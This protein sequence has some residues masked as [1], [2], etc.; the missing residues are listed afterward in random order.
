MNYYNIR[1]LSVSYFQKI[2]FYSSNTLEDSLVCCCSTYM[3]CCK[4]GITKEHNLLAQSRNNRIST[5]AVPKDIV[6]DVSG[7]VDVFVVCW[8]TSM[9]QSMNEVARDVVLEQW[10]HRPEA[11]FR[12]TL[13]D[14]WHS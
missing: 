3:I 13:S 8:F 14:L 11:S 6:L 4:V 7:C 9:V 5:V 2:D 1:C 12:G 10:C